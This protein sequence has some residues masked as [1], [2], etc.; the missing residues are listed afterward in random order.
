MATRRQRRQ[1][2]RYDRGG[3]LGRRGIAPRL[4]PGKNYRKPLA[5]KAAAPTP[6]APTAPT[7]DAVDINEDGGLLADYVNDL[8][9]AEQFAIPDSPRAMAA[10]REVLQHISDPD[11]F[12]GEKFPERSMMPLPPIQEEGPVVAGGQ[13]TG[14][15]P[16]VMNGQTVLVN[17]E[18]EIVWAPPPAAQEGPPAD[19]PV[20]LVPN[21][22]GHLVPAETMPEPG[23]H[24]LTDEDLARLRAE[25]DANDRT[26]D[27]GRPVVVDPVAE[28]PV[29][30][31][32]PKPLAPREPIAP[33]KEAPPLSEFG[34]PDESPG[35]N[36]VPGSPLLTSPF[37]NI[38]PETGAPEVGGPLRDAYLDE[39]WSKTQNTQLRGELSKFDANNDGV[40]SEQERDTAFDAFTKQAQG[41]GYKNIAEMVEESRVVKGQFVEKGDLNVLKRTEHV[42]DYLSQGI[43]HDNDPDTPN[44]VHTPLLHTSTHHIKNPRAYGNKGEHY[45]KPEMFEQLG[46]PRAYWRQINDL[47]QNKAGEFYQRIKMAE[48]GVLDPKN[49]KNPGKMKWDHATVSQVVNEAITQVYEQHAERG[50]RAP[51]IAQKGEFDRRGRHKPTVEAERKKRHDHIRKQAE[52]N[53][54]NPNRPLTQDEKNE[55][56]L[57]GEVDYGRGGVFGSGYGRTPGSRKALMKRVGPNHQRSMAN[58][59]DRL[60]KQE[61]AGI[62]RPGGTYENTGYATRQ[63]ILDAA[64]RGSTAAEKAQIALEKS[65]AAFEEYVGMGFSRGEA[66]EMATRV[67]QQEFK[68]QHSGVQ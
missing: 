61:E 56:Y 18:G 7:P 9:M 30:E 2:R 27:P 10:G 62:Y 44:V 23:P 49:P 29:E 24:P 42:P 8:K 39:L 52:I 65:N 55:R 51:H 63:R 67:Y 38:N 5:P 3:G 48:M 19:A 16:V 64:G 12:F 58:E 53:R 40:W 22:S 1:Q 54:N 20:P 15:K 26:Q 47:L 66:R 11:T 60:D 45:I 31:A 57:R 25:T 33:G 36:L 13:G 35:P 21:P 41:L 14:V 43:D 46:V 6:V 37:V 28:Q 34:I 68:F 50:D 59:I 32:R 4:F 17:G